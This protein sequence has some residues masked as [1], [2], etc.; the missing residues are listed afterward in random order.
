VPGQPVRGADQKVAGADGGVADLERKQ[1]FLSEEG[2][3]R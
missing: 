2:I 1:S 3:G